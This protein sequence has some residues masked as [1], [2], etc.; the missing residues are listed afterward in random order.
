M[1]KSATLSGFFP[2]KF[3]KTKVKVYGG[4]RPVTSPQALRSQRIP[5]SRT[6]QNL[7]LRTGY[8]LAFAILML[9]VV[10]LFSINYNVSTGY[11]ISKLQKHID[12]LKEENKRLMLRSS[13]VG[14]IASIQ[15]VSLADH[16]VPVT[17]VEYVQAPVSPL[18]LK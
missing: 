16:Y 3:A 2:L 17:A 10:H 14:S 4:Q 11:N 12:G 1:L 15:Q 5:V 18:G 9:F 6:G 7:R 13:E 8:A